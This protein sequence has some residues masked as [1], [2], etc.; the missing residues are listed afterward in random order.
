MKA[1]ERGLNSVRPISLMDKTFN[2]QAFLDSLAEELISN[3]DRA[4][5]ATTPGLVG[6]AREHDVRQK[7]QSVLPS[8]VGITSGCVIDSYGHTS[9]QVDV[10]LYEKE[11]CPIF[12][13]NGDP[14]STY[15]PCEGVIAAG[16]IKSTLGTKELTD[17]INKIAK[18]KNLIRHSEENT[19]F[20]KYGSSIAAQG[21][22]SES[23]D[24]INKPLDQI[25]GFILCHD[26]GLT[27][28]SVASRMKE[29][30]ASISPHLS[31]N[32]LISLKNGMAMFSAAS[33]LLENRKGADK[34]CFFRNADG[35]FQF[36]INKLAFIANHGRTTA[37]L[38]FERYLLKSHNKGSADA[39]F[40][41]L[42]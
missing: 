31:P 5:R 27:E 39:T 14:S 32:V 26:F 8:K 20:R 13:I 38:P 37:R 1:P 36:L 16:E 15:I 22:L 35:E 29:A 4:G 30:T 33:Q 12:S 17:A 21:A 25:Y 10:I 19:C 9:N 7:L 6:S 28:A 24:P 23:L 2:S 40:Y 3:F 42:A 41:P 11:Q 34:I 18:L